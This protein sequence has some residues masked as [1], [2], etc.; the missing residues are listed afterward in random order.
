M[1]TLTPSP[2]RVSSSLCLLGQPLPED[3][4][5]S[6]RP[7][8]APPNHPTLSS[9]SPKLYPERLLDLSPAGA[10]PGSTD[11]VPSTSLRWAPLENLAQGPQGTVGSLRYV[12]CLK[13][14]HAA[15]S[16]QSQTRQSLHESSYPDEVLPGCCAVG[17]GRRYRGLH[18]TLGVPRG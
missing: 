3:R 1:Q 6:A 18:L 4:A 9:S 14:P 8:P 7:R 17:Q 5:P 15:R 13:N 16:E 2:P 11:P 12:N 10:F